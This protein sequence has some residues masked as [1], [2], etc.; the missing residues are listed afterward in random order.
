MAKSKAKT[1]KFEV[2]KFNLFMKSTDND[3]SGMAKIGSVVEL[4]VDENGLPAK[5]YHGKVRSLSAA[6][7]K[8]G[9]DAS[10]EVA[11]LKKENADLKKQIE[12][13]T[14]QKELV[15]NPAQ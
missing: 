9:A 4:E 12:E 14:A 7:A 8:L 5:R 11:A 3:D 15:T 2:V 1:E 13:L 6:K 10:K